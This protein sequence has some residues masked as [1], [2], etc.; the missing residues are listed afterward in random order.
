M[1]KPKRKLNNDRPIHHVKTYVV[2]FVDVIP[3]VCRI[4]KRVFYFVVIGGRNRVMIPFTTNSVLS[5]QPDCGQSVV[6]EKK[7]VRLFFFNAVDT[8]HHC[9]MYHHNIILHSLRGF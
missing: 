9:E 4:T 6:S 2:I 5:V 8:S 1:M 3:S 7:I